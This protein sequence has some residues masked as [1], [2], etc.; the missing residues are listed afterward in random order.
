MVCILVFSL[1]LCTKRTRAVGLDLPVSSLTQIQRPS[2]SIP[3]CAAIDTEK[4]EY[5]ITTEIQEKL[6]FLLLSNMPVELKEREVNELLKKIRGGD[7]TIHLIV[8]FFVLYVM[9]SQNPEVSSF[10]NNFQTHRNSFDP[11]SLGDKFQ[12]TLYQQHRL[13]NSSK[14]KLI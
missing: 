6:S 5:Q 9:N 8:L 1:I 11:S 2:L 3:K 13:Y 4:P 12:Q 14:V 7:S 10:L